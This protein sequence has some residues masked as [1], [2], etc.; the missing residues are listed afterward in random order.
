MQNSSSRVLARM[1]RMQAVLARTVTAKRSRMAADVPCVRS[2]QTEQNAANVTH[3][4]C[5]LLSL[6]SSGTASRI[7]CSSHYQV[8][9]FYRLAYAQ[10][11]MPADRPGKPLLRSS[12]KTHPFPSSQTLNF[13]SQ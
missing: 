10:R 9:S 7:S 11:T 1:A 13:G 3:M 2:S 8:T 4:C 6:Y 5:G 12:C